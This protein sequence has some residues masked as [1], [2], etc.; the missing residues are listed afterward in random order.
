MAKKEIKTQENVTPKMSVK[1]ALEN[2]PNLSLRKLALAVDVCYGV[3]LKASKKPI[4]GAP[5]DPTNV[6]YAEVDAVL[7]RKEIDISTLDLAA[8]AG[9]ARA[10]A[11]KEVDLAVGDKFT[12]RGREEQYVIVALTKTHVCIQATEANEFGEE[13]LRSMSIATFLHQ[14]PKKVNGEA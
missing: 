6:N 2:T 10:K 13:I 11:T 1:E 14:T 8:I 5:Y 7:A 9:E 4:A 12:I 3:L